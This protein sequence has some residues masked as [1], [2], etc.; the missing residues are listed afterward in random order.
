MGVLEPFAFLLL[1]TVLAVV[2]LYLLRFRR[3]VAPI[4]NV[5]LWDRTLRDREANTLW[6]KLRVSV[7]LFVQILV[8]LLLIVAL[9]RPWTLGTGERVQHA[10]L[11]VDVSA[12]MGA[13][14]PLDDETRLSAAREAARRAVDD[15][16]GNATA[17]L[18][19]AGA[20]PNVVVSA[21][22]DKARLAI[23]PV[24]G[25]IVA[26][27]RFA[28]TLTEGRR[29]AAIH[30]FSDGAFPEVRDSVGLDRQ[31]LVWVPIGQPPEG[32]LESAIPTNQG[33]TALEITER[34]GSPNS[35][36][37]QVANS[38][39]LTVTRR[40]EVE[41]DNSP[42]EARTLELGPG[43]TLATD[44]RD[45]PAGA[46]VIGAKLAGT[47]EFALDDQAWVVSR[48]N[49]P[50]NVLLVSEGNRFAEVALQLLTGVTLYRVPPD[51]YTPDAQVNGRPFDITVIDAG[52]PVTVLATLS[53]TNLLVFAP[54]GTF[55]GISVTGTIANPLPRAPSA[56]QEGDGPLLDVAGLSN[57]QIARASAIRADGSRDLLSSDK[58]SL[59][60][61]TE[62]DGFKVVTVAF[63]LADSDLPLQSAFPILM[64]DLVNL[65]RPDAQLDFPTAVNPGASV[66]L[67]PQNGSVT[68]ILVEDPTGRE[69]K[70]RG[71]GEPVIFAETRLPGTYY[72]TQYAAERVAWQGAFAVNLFA[73]NESIFAPNASALEPLQLIQ[74]TRL[75]RAGSPT[76]TSRNEIW[77]TFAILGLVVLLGEWAYANRIAIRRAVTEAR[78]RR[79]V[80]S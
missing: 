45:L 43:Q 44:I 75:D 14:L 72:V 20:E 22:G 8:L 71:G 51:S 21:T 24:E 50:I 9:A 53:Q 40:V 41:V 17:T 37:V 67:S 33:I 52:V 68:E 31:R 48:S 73:R 60:M 49:A 69:W 12:S 74:E 32:L 54:L 19:A 10:V 59:I 61:L 30:V 39:S 55:H 78:T 4:P 46:R 35:L 6:Q 1:P 5:T 56:Q 57:I 25:D 16:D 36:F 23:E 2:A 64:R 79:A 11:I 7:L 70:Y 28:G 76:E 65:L 63:A 26:A 27:L 62:R 34:A 77:G 3:P 80:G 29:D 15:L 38:G 42:W 13:V 66:L 18:I 58:G 47:D